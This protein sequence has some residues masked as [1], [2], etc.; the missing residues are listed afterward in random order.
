MA[1]EVIKRDGS[2]QEFAAEKIRKSVEAAAREGGLSEE[3]IG[4]IVEKASAP[5][6]SW[7]E[8]QEEVSTS[9]IRERLLAE[10]A[11]VAPEAVEGWKAYDERRGK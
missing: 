5:V 7:A 10:L 2:R 3:R 6:L 11:N 8:E 4:E 1:K 9:E